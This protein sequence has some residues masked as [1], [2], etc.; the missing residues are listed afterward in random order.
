[1]AVIQEIETNTTAQEAFWRK[2]QQFRFD[3]FYY[4]NHYKNCVTTQRW[5]KYVVVGLTSASTLIWMQWSTSHTVTTVCSVSILVLQ[6][7]NAISDLFP[8]NNRRD[9]LR[10]LTDDLD[11]LYIEMESTWR[12]IAEGKLTLSEIYRSVDDFAQ[13]RLQIE[14]NYL[15]NDA[16]PERKRIRKNAENKTHDYFE[17]F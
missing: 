13:R 16:L 6:V 12:K 2:L 14:R 7:F 9:E 15:K 4:N 10:S 5:I 11:P 1:M 17:N 3:L 8:F